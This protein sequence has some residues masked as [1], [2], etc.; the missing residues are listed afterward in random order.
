MN[1]ITGITAAVL[2][3]FNAMMMI[4]DP[5][6]WSAYVDHFTAYTIALAFLSILLSIFDLV[7]S[8]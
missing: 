7:R 3:V 4:A 6:Y 5:T 8:E 1:R 2:G